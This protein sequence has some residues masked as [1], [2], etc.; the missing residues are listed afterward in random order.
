M[1]TTIK[2]IASIQTGV[3]AK[4]VARGEIAYLQPKYYDENGVLIASLQPDLNAEGISNK[5]IL[6]QGDVLFASKGIKNFAALFNDS[7]LSAAASTSFFV[8]RLQ[9]QNVLPEFLTWFLNQPNTLRF[10]KRKAKGTSMASISKTVLADLEI[11][12]P[13]MQTQK[14]ILKIYQ[15]RNLEKELKQQIE[16][17]RETQIQQQIFNALK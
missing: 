2:H 15:L 6:K 10:L 1:K 9:E 5:H 11:S 3:F 12:I 7:R 14:L 13:D 17:L 16:A 8:I 4:P